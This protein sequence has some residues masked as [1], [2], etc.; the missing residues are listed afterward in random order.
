MVDNTWNTIKLL[1][2][3]WHQPQ[4]ANSGNIYAYIGSEDDLNIYVEQFTDLNTGE[5]NQL[6]NTLKFPENTVL[7]YSLSDDGLKMLVGDSNS[8]TVT[9]YYYNYGQSM[10]NS[11]TESTS[12]SSYSYVI[13]Q[14]SYNISYNTSTTY[15]VFSYET[16]TGSIPYIDGY[17]LNIKAYAKGGDSYG[18][19]TNTSTG[20]L[21][22]SGGG[23]GGASFTGIYTGTQSVNVQVDTYGNIDI[24]TTDGESL[25]LQSGGIGY[26]LL[27]DLPDGYNTNIADSNQS[28]GGLGGIATPTSGFLSLFTSTNIANG[29]DGANYLSSNSV[30]TQSDEPQGGNPGI[31]NTYNY[32]TGADGNYVAGIGEGNPIYVEVSYVLASSSDG[33]PEPEADSQPPEPAPEPEPEGIAVYPSDGNWDILSRISLQPNSDYSYICPNSVS[34]SGDGTHYNVSLLGQNTNGYAVV[35]KHD[36][37][38]SSSSEPEPPPIPSGYDYLMVIEWDTGIFLKPGSGSSKGSHVGI[39]GGLSIGENYYNIL[40]NNG[41]I[42]EGNVGIGTITPSYELD[43]NGTINS[44]NLIIDGNTTLNNLIINGSNQSIDL[45]GIILKTSIDTQGNNN[46]TISNLND[47]YIESQSYPNQRLQ[48]GVEAENKTYLHF[49]SNENYTTDYDCEIATFGFTGN[50]L[51][52]YG[53]LHIESGNILTYQSPIITDYN[54]TLQSITS[55]NTN[56]VLEIRNSC[57]SST[58][59]GSQILFTNLQSNLSTTS[60][61]G[62]INA[63]RTNNS[64]NGTDYSSYMNF[65]VNNGSGIQDVIRIDSSAHVGIGTTSPNNSLNLKLPVDNTYDGFRIDN[66]SGDHRLIFYTDTNDNGYIQLRNSS[67][68]TNVFFTTS[69]S[70]YLNGGNFGIG[71]SSPQAQLHISSKTDAIFRLE[72]DSDNVN[73]GDNLKFNYIKMVVL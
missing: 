63:F 60:F 38:G 29:T 41:L 11:I 33:E 66:S 55:G 45:N 35:Y 24:S 51:S 47:L 58:N 7:T 49:N 3:V 23:G 15:S 18:G 40:Y 46:L 16:T 73:E 28:G 25:N 48:F 32:G 54:G 67:D 13:D 61:L 31:T 43:V 21:E 17:N 50:N 72:A 44:N 34:L 42:V 37:S 65:S 52:G 22:Y 64:N 19:N 57:N 2:N 1:C 39:E 9:L 62:A 69:G 20:L 26:Y 12:N 53:E 10:S 8:N 56:S 59:Y 14:N 30:L 6:G 4:L 5:S 36:V 70:S 27:S 68:T 71:T